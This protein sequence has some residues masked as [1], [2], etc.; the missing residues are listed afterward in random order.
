[1]KQRLILLLGVALSVGS[2]G[3]AQTPS[4]TLRTPGLSQPVEIVRDRWG[5]NHIYAQN[6]GDLFFAQGYAA[7]KDRLFQLEIWRRQASG[8]VAE[9]LGRRALQ[10]DIGSRLHKFRGDL[11]AELNHYHPRGKQIIEAFT[12][13]VNAYIAETERN[14][15]LLPIEF[16]ALG[17][18]PARWTPDV[19]ISRHGAL[20]SN[21]TDEVSFARALKVAT[22]DQV[23]ELLYFQG[24]DPIFTLDSSIDVKVFPDNVLELYSAF[25]SA[26]DFRPAD[27]SAELR[28]A[29]VALASPPISENALDIGS[30]N[31]VLAGSRTQSTYPLLA[32]DP[33]RAITSPSLRYWVHLVAPGW[34]VIGAGEPAIPGVS[35]GHNEQGAWGLTIFGNDSED[36]YVYETNPANPNEYRY[37]GNWEAMR[38]V[39]E[40]IPIKGEKPEQVQLKYTRHGPVLSAD[41]ANHKAYALRA[42]WLEPGG[43]PYLASL[44][45]DQAK[46]WQQFRD[47]CS[48]SR[49]TADRKSVV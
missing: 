28:G 16:R 11:D 38:V 6:E 36:L 47:A 1:M 18:K 40:T 39:A 27:V 12:R 19:V 5:I 2:T 29:S 13:G 44:R 10:R 23:R 49:M 26:V 22:V 32:N 25:R 35:I 9:I 37:Q 3:G 20:T 41:R 21:V 33:H 8:T 15:A 48:Y 17:I 4:A 43:A 30:N 31:W 46:T 7:A 45:M 24:G 14:P 34:N 42:A